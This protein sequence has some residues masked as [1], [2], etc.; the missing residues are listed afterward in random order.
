MVVGRFPYDTYKEKSTLIRALIC[1]GIFMV[2]NGM[3]Q[4]LRDLLTRI[5]VPEASKRI[6][7]EQ[8]LKHPWVSLE[9]EAT[10]GSKIKTTLMST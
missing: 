5:F 1:N 10:K 3:S 9:K 8:I 7:L 6:T 2:P 4:E